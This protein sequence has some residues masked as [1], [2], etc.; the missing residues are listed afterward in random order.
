MQIKWE[1]FSP[2]HPY[3]SLCCWVDICR[4]LWGL[5]A[6][7]QADFCNYTL[8]LSVSK[9][10]TDQCSLHPDRSDCPGGQH[11]DFPPASGGALRAGGLLVPVRCLE[12]RRHHQEPESLRP[13][14]MWVLWCAP[15]VWW[16]SDE[17]KRNP[18]RLREIFR[19]QPLRLCVLCSY[20][21]I[22]KLRPSEIFTR[23]SVYSLLKG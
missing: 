21:C 22:L 17:E 9:P 8:F 13:H 18:C 7:L 1:V 19:F 15:W 4:E 20:W 14:C 16:C 2:S 23:V 6:A 11:R 3:D 5:P 10:S 12:L